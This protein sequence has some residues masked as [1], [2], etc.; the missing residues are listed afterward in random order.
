MAETLDV[1][2]G[3]FLAAPIPLEM[4]GN[5]CSH[6]CHYCFANLNT[7]DR[8]MSAKSIVN[9]LQDYPNR[10]TLAAKLLQRGCP[11]VISNRVDPFSASNW[12]Q[13]LPLMEMMAELGLPIAIQ[14]KG[15]KGVD[16][17]L[18]FLPPSV[19][20]VTITFNEDKDDL[21]AKVKPGTPSISDRLAMIEAVRAAGHQVVVGINPAVPEW[22]PKP[23]VLISKLKALGVHGV[24]AEVMHLSQRQV[25][26]IPARGKEAMGDELIS[27]AK[28]TNTEEDNTHLQRV[29]CAAQ[30]AGMEVFSIG[31]HIESD[32]FRPY[33][34]TYG[35]DKVFPTVQGFVNCAHDYHQQTSEQFFYFDDFK[36]YALQHFPKGT[37]R[38]GSYVASKARAFTAKM[39]TGEKWSNWMTYE[40]LLQYLWNYG[41]I[42]A[43]PVR[44]ECFAYAVEMKGED[45]IYLDDENGNAIYRFNPTGFKEYTSNV[46]EELEICL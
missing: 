31:Q 21:R 39:P 26:G 28:K 42:S 29:R 2:Y 38:L 16:E 17:A 8:Q 33:I 41:E 37:L 40:K 5:W 23:E 44:T 15:G 34:E 18:K 1:F 10:D 7:P 43:S 22:M 11:T 25:D 14:T 19:W 13:M 4:S 46:K 24:W 45:K 30:D 35:E 9:L 12:R 6:S 32:F 20:Y 36:D 27:R 3:E